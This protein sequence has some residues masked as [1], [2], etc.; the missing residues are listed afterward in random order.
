MTTPTLDQPYESNNDPNH[1]THIINPPMNTHIWR[2]NMTTQDVVDLARIK[3]LEV[4]ALCGHR[5]VPKGDPKKYKRCE[6]CLDRAM[7]LIRGE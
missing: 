1:R 2:P 6:P 4:V 3:G 7:E 5:W